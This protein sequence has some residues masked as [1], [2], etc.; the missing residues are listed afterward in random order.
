[1][2]RMLQV[3]LDMRTTQLLVPSVVLAIL[4]SACATTNDHDLAAARRRWNAQGITSY[5][6]TSAQTCFCPS[7][8]TAPM[9]VSVI[10]GDAIGSATYVDGGGAVPAAVLSTLFTVER[11]F[12]KVQDA[13][14]RDADILEVTFDPI[15]GYPTRVKIDYE[16]RAADDEFELTLSGLTPAR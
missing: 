16:R 2:A 12:A 15:L 6:V 5:S 14:D 7:E 1:M 8:I 3:A 4:A 11:A 13:I 9:H 10:G